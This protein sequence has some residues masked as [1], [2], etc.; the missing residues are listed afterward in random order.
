M[1]NLIHFTGLLFSALIFAVSPLQAFHLDGL[2]R[3]DR[4]N[5]TIRIESIDDGF[6]AKRTDQGIWYKYVAQDEHHYADRY[7]NYYELHSEDEITWHEA[8]TGKRISF[9]KVDYR[10]EYAWDDQYEDDHP[11]SDEDDYEWDDHRDGHG[12][13]PWMDRWYSHHRDRMDGRWV[14]AHRRIEIEIVSFKGGLKVKRPYSGWVKYYPDR[15]DNCFRDEVGN[16]IQVIDR[17]TLQWRSYHG[18]HDRI[19]H[20]R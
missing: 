14:D 9:F 13:K 19:F 16:S 3:N 20:R 5:L 15:H 17:N 6:R 18:R 7:G 11:Y 1:K 10:D 12:H 2:W 4:Q 8:S